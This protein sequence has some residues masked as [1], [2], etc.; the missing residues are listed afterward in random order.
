[1]VPP[2][3]LSHRR[4]L[5]VICS[6]ASPCASRASPFI[7]IQELGEGP[8]AV[9]LNGS[10]Q[11]PMR[12][13]GMPAGLQ[14]GRDQLLR[15]V[16]PRQVA[17]RIALPFRAQMR[18][19]FPLPDVPYTERAELLTASSVLEQRR[20]DCPVALA[21]RVSGAGASRG[22]RACGSP[23]AGAT[24][25]RFIERGRFTPHR[26][27]PGPASPVQIGIER[28]RAASLRRMASFARS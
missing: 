18:H 25:S 20:Q 15:P 26:V 21:F 8:G 12:L 13:A 9:V 22:I 14:V 17:P 27:M 6:D 16:M 11:R 19:P 10:K 24:P 5:Y 2:T 28:G 23:S 3:G 1:M 4:C 7:K